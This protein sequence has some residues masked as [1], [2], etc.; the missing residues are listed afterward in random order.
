M[1]TQTGAH[2]LVVLIRTDGT[3][4]LLQTSSPDELP[5]LD[6][7]VQT[8]SDHFGRNALQPA[9]ARADRGAAR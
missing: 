9:P 7:P 5:P 4:L 1:S 8:E 6:L 3:E 2:E